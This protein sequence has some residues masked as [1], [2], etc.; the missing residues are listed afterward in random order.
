MVF[1]PCNIQGTAL[2][3]SADGKNGIAE[4]IIN[5]H[6]A[7]TLLFYIF[8][9]GGNRISHLHAVQIKTI[10]LGVDDYTL[11]RVKTLL[12]YISTLDKRH[13]RKIEM[14]GKSIVT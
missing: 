11:F 2:P 12:A 1:R 14:T 3:N 7:D 10:T 4:T 8:L 13:Y 9:G 6:L 5:L